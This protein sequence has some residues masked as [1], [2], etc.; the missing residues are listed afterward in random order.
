MPT[1]NTNLVIRYVVNDGPVTLRLEV[2]NG[3]EA[4]HFLYRPHTSGSEV[5]PDSKDVPIG[6]GIDL[7]GFRY[8]IRSVLYDENQAT[9]RVA[10]TID[11]SG[12]PAPHSQTQ[13]YTLP[14]DGTLM[15]RTLID[16]VRE[17]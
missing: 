15:V 4:D 16:F 13:Y 9:D 11:I 2:G 5:V 10:L 14:T 8:R 1:D 6:S 17:Q 7:A 3:Q 12:G